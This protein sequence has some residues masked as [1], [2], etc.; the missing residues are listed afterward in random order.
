MDVAGAVIRL[1][2]LD[3]YALRLTAWPL[4]ATLGVTLIALILERVLRLLDALALSNDRFGFVVELA[5]NLAPHYIGLALPAAFFVALFLVAARLNDGSEID[6]MLASGRS[7]VRLTAPFI[8]LGVVLMAFSLALFG[9]LQP[10]SRY[11]YR[12]VMHAAQNAG[13][14][15]DLPGGM[16]VSSGDGF[17]ITADSSEPGGRMLHRL[18]VRQVGKDGTEMVTTAAEAEIRPDPA[19]DVA[20]LTLR[21]GTQLR[22]TARGEAALLQF[23]TSSVEL[24]LG[25]VSDLMRDRGKDERELTSIE[26]LEQ[27]GNPDSTIGYGALMGEFLARLARALTLPFLP[28]LAVPLGLASKRSGRTSG[29]IVAGVTLV[30]FQ[31]FLQLGESLAEGGK[32]SPY[33]GVGGPFV[34]FA[35]LCLWIFL[36]SRK[37]PGDTPVARLISAI[38]SLAQRIAAMVRPAARAEP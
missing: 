25:T 17:V 10:Y 3:R 36:S 6:A 13:W 8:A 38:D 31:H 30:A 1:S 33:L 24:P 4:L 9:F 18:F 21:Q 19:S 15:G 7:L 20:V 37:R 26:L 27:V 28:L 16:V 14:S 23:T 35:A 32:M 29:V 22:L 12:A 34:L 2:I 5:A 11:T